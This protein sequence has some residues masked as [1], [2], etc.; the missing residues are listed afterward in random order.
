MDVHTAAKSEQ[1]PPDLAAVNM[2][3][4]SFWLETRTLM[5]TR[6]PVMRLRLGIA[7]R[8]TRFALSVIQAGYKARR[9]RFLRRILSV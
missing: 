6:A 7:E 4:H 8:L 9:L 2:A 3:S 1:T 5:T